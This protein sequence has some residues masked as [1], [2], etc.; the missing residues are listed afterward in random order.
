MRKAD[1]EVYTKKDD[2]PSNEAKRLSKTDIKLIIVKKMEK[3]RRNLDDKV[4][5]IQD[6]G[7]QLQNCIDANS[8][9]M[10]VQMKSW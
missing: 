2:E 10:K 9:E 6:E 7:R 8:K 5:D 3:V 1:G 4:A